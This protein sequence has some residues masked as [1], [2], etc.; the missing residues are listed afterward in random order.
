MTIPPPSSH[1]PERAPAPP[2]APAWQPLESIQRRVLGV[3]IEKAKTTPAAYPLT[4]NSVVTGCN[5]KSN[6]EPVMEL[7]DGEVER[8]I[9]QLRA[10]GVVTDV[11]DSGRVTKYRHHGY[12][13]LGVD[14]AEIAVMTELLLRG[15]QSLGDLRVRAAR[16]EPIPDL[17]ALKPLVAALLA[18]GL[19]VELTPPGRGQIVSHGLYPEYEMSQLRARHAGPT[20]AAAERAGHGAHVSV[21]PSHA[22]E[23]G[24]A[25]DRFG[26]LSAEIAELR[27]EVAR[28][29]ERVR[30]LERERGAEHS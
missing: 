24:A 30:E 26:A 8:A 3:L 9:D 22:A 16:M 29:E 6:R 19:M 5:Q 18:R 27:A 25:P 23:R 13:W 17:S 10:L 2:P 11:Y 14:K 20:S 15:E 1:P 21:A 4:L 7:D 12:V 28:L